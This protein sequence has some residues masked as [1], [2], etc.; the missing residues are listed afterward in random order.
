[1]EE[2]LEDMRCKELALLGGRGGY[3][4]VRVRRVRVGS[5]ENAVA[6]RTL[7]EV[8]HRKAQLGQ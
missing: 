5:S 7:E 1:M 6:E 4:G 3:E 8:R 2:E